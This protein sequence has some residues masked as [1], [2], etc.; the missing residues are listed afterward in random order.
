MFVMSFDKLTDSCFQIGH[1][2]E[3]APVRRSSF[4]L[5]KPALHGVQPG[6]AGRGKVQFETWMLF[7]PLLDRAALWVELLSS[8]T[9]K[10]SLTSVLRT[11]CCRKARNSMARWRWVIRPMTWPQRQH[12]LSTIQ[13]LDLSFLVNRQHQRVIRRVSIEPNH[14]DRPCRRNGDHC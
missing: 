2:G 8:I 12:R 7:Q 13:S 5:C 6:C 9:C 1:A 10:S 11:I 3:G 14:V 4:L